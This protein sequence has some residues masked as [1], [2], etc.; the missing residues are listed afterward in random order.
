MASRTNLNNARNS[1]KRKEKGT[2]LASLPAAFQSFSQKSD[3]TADELI[4]SLADSYENRRAR[5]VGEWVR[6]QNVRRP[7]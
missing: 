2:Y 4:I 7:V 1:D 3:R 6:Q 5:Q